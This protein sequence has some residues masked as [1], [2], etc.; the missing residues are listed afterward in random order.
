MLKHVFKLIIVIT[1][2]YMLGVLMLSSCSVLPFNKIMVA[3]H[4]NYGKNCAEC[5]STTFL[6][7]RA[8]SKG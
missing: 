7:T 2:L 8:K 5:H 4:A 1:L 3:P 6:L